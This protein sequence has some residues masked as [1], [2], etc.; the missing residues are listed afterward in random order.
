MRF[1]F[2]GVPH[3]LVITHKDKAC[4]PRTPEEETLKEELIKSLQ[5][6]ATKHFCVHEVSNYH[7]NDPVE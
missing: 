7:E 3:V 1:F 5:L 2:L 4:D 6:G